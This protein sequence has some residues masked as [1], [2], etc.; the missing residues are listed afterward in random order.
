MTLEF[1]AL[2]FRHCCWA[3]WLG[4]ISSK[5][6]SYFGV[7]MQK[8]PYCFP[9]I[10]VFLEWC[11]IISKV[12]GIIKVPI[13]SYKRSIMNDIGLLCGKPLATLILSNNY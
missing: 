3:E 7:G 6:G 1:G 5:E 8:F 10:L 9:R 12:F 13:V 11:G 4:G 2:D